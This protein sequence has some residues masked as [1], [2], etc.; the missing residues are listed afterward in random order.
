MV[1]GACPDDVHAIGAVV[2]V[3]NEVLSDLGDGIRIH[4]P[5]DRLFGDREFL[6][7]N[8]PE[9]L[10]GTRNE[11]SRVDVVGEAGLEQVDRHLV[12]GIHVEVRMV[13]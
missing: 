13:P 2:H 5:Q 6:L 3:A 4:R 11:D 8:L 7:L 1:E 10:T 9:L 12:V